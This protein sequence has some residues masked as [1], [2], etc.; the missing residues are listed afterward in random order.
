MFTPKIARSSK[1]FLCLAPSFM[2]LVSVSVDTNNLL[3]RLD[4]F[5]VASL[6]YLQVSLCNLR[7]TK[8]TEVRIADDCNAN[9]LKDVSEK[10]MRCHHTNTTWLGRPDSTISRKDAA[11]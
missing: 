6:K 4:I 11:A 5:L 2:N 1:L 8:M 10:L 9:V 3:Q 7:S